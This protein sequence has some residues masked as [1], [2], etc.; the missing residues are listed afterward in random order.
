MIEIIIGIIFIALIL[1]LNSFAQQNM[2]NKYSSNQNYKR[3]EDLQD[4]FIKQSDKIQD[5][6]RKP[7]ISISLH[8]SQFNS[9]FIEQMS[10]IEKKFDLFIILDDTSF[11]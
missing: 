7:K 3:R 9:K 8:H 10:I 11:L 1:Y 2:N 6:E 4:Q 5:K